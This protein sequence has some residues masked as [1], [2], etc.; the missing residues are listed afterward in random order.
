[1][2]MYSISDEVYKFYI[3]DTKRGKNASK[4]CVERKLVAMS[5]VAPIVVDNGV[6]CK[7]YQFGTFNFLVREDSNEVGMVFWSQKPCYVPDENSKR[8]RELY[9]L[10]GLSDDG[11]SIIAP[12]NEVELEDY[13]SKNN[14]S[15]EGTYRNFFVEIFEDIIS[16]VSLAKKE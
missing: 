11:Q 10:I 14:L 3:E 1:M 16:E 6:G 4:E 5:L 12:I 9:K 7:R 2:K 8:L 15:N 13:C